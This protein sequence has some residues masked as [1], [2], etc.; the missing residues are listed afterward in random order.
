M[1]GLSL[2]IAPQLLR[3]PHML[4]GLAVKEEIF[5]YRWGNPANYGATGTKIFDVLHDAHWV[6]KNCPRAGSIVAINNKGLTG[7][8]QSTIDWAKPTLNGYLYNYTP[9]TALPPSTFD[10]RILTGAYT[11]NEGGSVQ[12][13]NG[14]TQ[15]TLAFAGTLQI[16]EFD[17]T[18]TKLWEYTSGQIAQSDR[19]T[20]CEMDTNSIRAYFD[21]FTYMKCPG[22]S[23]ITLT[24][25]TL[26]GNGTNTYQWSS[27][28]TA[29]SY[30][31]N[32]SIN[33]NP[34]STT[35]YTV[36]VTSNTCTFS[37][38]A[39]V[40]INTPLVDAGNNRA[41]PTGSSTLLKATGA[42]TY[43]WSNGKTSDTNTVNPTA[44]T[45]YYVTGT[46]SYGCTAIDS[47]VVTVVP[48]I[49]I[50]L[51]ASP[52]KQCS[53]DSSSIIAN[54]SG[55]NGIYTF[56]WTSIPSGFNSTSQNIKVA[57][58]ATTNYKLVVSSGGIKDS[59]IVIDTIL[60]LPSVDA[61]FNLTILN[62][63]SAFLKATGAASYIWSNGKN[64]DTNTVSP[65]ITTKYYVTGTG[66]NSCVANDSITITVL[67]AFVTTISASP[68]PVCLGDSI[69]LGSTASGAIGIYTY[70]WSSTPA[71]FTSTIKNPKAKVTAN[72]TYRLI[73]TSGSFKDTQYIPVNVIA[74]P[75][76]DAGLDAT[77][78]YGQSSLLTATGGTSYAWSNGANTDTTTVSPIFTTK[79]F[80][81]VSA[82]S[83]F[84]KD[85][86]KITVNNAPLV[87]GSIISSA[88]TICQGD[89][90]KLDI[91]PNGAT[92]SYSYKWTSNS[93]GLNSNL[94]NPTD[95][96]NSS[97]TYK[98][99]ITSG[100]YK[101]S[102][103]KIIVVKPNQFPMLDLIKPSLL[104]IAHC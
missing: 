92:Y 31:T 18:G 10:K 79:Y 24:S 49:V 51:S 75:I 58:S 25:K 53:K 32:A 60:A 69:Q 14:N 63:Q 90:I 28:P 76:A 45:T 42:S 57:P 19:F 74:L 103:T 7:P 70:A 21:T 5:L 33:V 47:V 3:L 98:V 101:D 1:N 100:I 89:S 99:V 2:I 82:N 96:P 6:P 8:N 62:G 95:L 104:E 72:I 37:A 50:A 80:V 59:A 39:I 22:S 44:T 71:G 27:Y 52:T 20:T 64:T 91:N 30:G 26:K 11:S 68:N 61:G 13:P 88:D 35:S 38:S 41:I 86:V 93:S 4:G 83:C 73:T 87:I 36:T 78:N 23:P 43:V 48:K 77:I 40:R 46:N 9:G 16:K 54:V 102:T 94:K 15:V 67:P 66:A 17:S 85:S 12:F 84:A 97:Q 81:T 56:Q 55:G 29:G 65:S 34:T